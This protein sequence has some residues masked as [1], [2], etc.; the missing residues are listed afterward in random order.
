MEK[1]SKVKVFMIYPVPF[2][3]GVEAHLRMKVFYN[4]PPTFP[5]N[6]RLHL[7]SKREF[8]EFWINDKHPGKNPVCSHHYWRKR[9]K[10][11]LLVTHLQSWPRVFCFLGS[12]EMGRPR[13][14]LHCPGYFW[15]VCWLLRFF[16][17]R[18]LQGILGGA[19]RSNAT[20]STGFST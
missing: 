16:S 3:T 20:F 10:S 6:L 19:L 4:F 8:R 5:E 7:L 11:R 13:L 14:T 18:F 2:R 1:V 9:C 15:P 17:F 12:I